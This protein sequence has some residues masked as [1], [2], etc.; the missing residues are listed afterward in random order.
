MDGSL[1]TDPQT[2]DLLVLG[3]PPV[4]P[5]IDVK[6][7]G[8]LV[9]TKV[10][11]E[12]A[13]EI[14]RSLLDRVE[15]DE[16]ARA[17]F[18]SK[19]TDN[20]DLLGVGAESDPDDLEYEA[21]D[22][23]DH[24]LLLT[25]LLRFTSKALS[26]LMPLPDMVAR[27]EAAQDFNLIED[28]QMRDDARSDVDGAIRRVEAFYTEYLLRGDQ[29]YRQDLDSLLFQCG[30][31]GTGIRKIYND[32]TR[33]RN[34][35]R[36]EWVP[37]QD[38]IVSYTSGRIAHRIKMPTSDM[39]RALKTKVYVGDDL[40]TTEEAADEDS[41]TEK[42]DEIAGIEKNVAAGGEKTLYEVYTHLFMPEDS[43]EMRIARPYVVTIHPAS[44][45]VISIRRNWQPYDPDELAIESFVVYLFAPGSRATQGMGLGQILGN[46]TRALRSAQ[47][48]GLDAGKLQN[49]PFGFKLS[50][51][52]IRNDSGKIVPGTL[53]DV[54]SPTDDIR[55]AVQPFQ[56]SGV[57]PGLIQLFQMLQENGREL[58]GIASIDFAAMMKSGVAAG[59]AMAAFEE[60][61]EFQTAVHRRLYDANAT[62]LRLLHD[63]MQEAVAGRPVSFGD[64][65]TLL[66]DDLKKV[67]L[68]PVMR[69]GQASR[70][71]DL[72]EAQGIFDAAASM[73]DIVDRRKAGE[74]YLRALGR[75]DIDDF[76]LPD[77][78]E[79]E[80]VPLDPASEYGS[81]LNGNPVKAGP[82]QD[83]MAH[84]EAHLSQMRM[85]Q[86]GQLPVDQGQA[87]LAVLSAHIVEHHALDMVVQVASRMGMQMDAFANGLPPEIERS[88]AP[89]IAEITK[90]LE[91]ERAPPEGEQQESKLQIEQVKG[92]QAIQKTTLEQQ[93]E[94]EMADLRHKQQMEL[95]EAKDEAALERAIQDDQTAIEIARMP[96]P[97]T[98]SA[99]AG[100]VSR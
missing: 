96:K 15:S 70:Q 64:G 59:P 100:V 13:Q 93:H 98:A 1:Y 85:V 5:Y 88:I 63:R 94:R 87:A 77:P 9:G 39:I 97:N 69:P 47:R 27:A 82:A 37:V 84:I 36:V 24:P 71:R 18:I 78:S 80:V 28:D 49:M 60:S 62:E 45:K 44:H 2:G 54:D 42:E 57:S 68:R 48:S 83:H 74:N 53:L 55:K 52:K 6:H 73:P 56:F 20:M 8:N 58:G 66:P 3:T 41:L 40:V 43:N 31:H 76:L 4:K 67:R 51:M 30:L 92:Q 29:T 46:V 50:G 34:Q 17:D 16:A 61:A 25:S 75:E 33:K 35:T 86:S 19:M 99:R 91:A 72:L 90:Q 95:Q 21:A 14:C 81:I 26:S 79:I 89:Q 22:T 38:L 10:S 65:E 7:F 23:S 32:P 11:V 12:R